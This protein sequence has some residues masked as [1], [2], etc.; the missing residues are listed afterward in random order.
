MDSRAYMKNIC[1]L[2]IKNCVSN[3]IKPLVNGNERSIHQKY[4][5]FLMIEIYKYVNYLLPQIVN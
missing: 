1:V 5:D 3:F 4:P 2:Y